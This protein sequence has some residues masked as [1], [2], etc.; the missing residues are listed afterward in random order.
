MDVMNYAAWGM[1]LPVCA[2]DTR[3]V[4]SVV[5]SAYAGL[6]PIKT[7]QMTQQFHIIIIIILTIIIIVLLTKSKVMGGFRTVNW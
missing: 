5:L 1:F 6:A 3:G 4:S 7:K 2:S